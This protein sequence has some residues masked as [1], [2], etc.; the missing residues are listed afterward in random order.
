M[1]SVETLITTMNLEDA[2]ALLKEMNVKSNFLIGNQ[3]SENSVK[4]IEGGLVISTDMRGVGQNRNSILERASADICVL[5][6]DDMKFCD[7]YE[8]IVSRVFESDPNIDVA[9]FNFIE[10]SQGRRVSTKRKKVR[11]HNY[12]NYGAAR[13]AFR[14]DSIKYKGITFNTKFGGGTPHQCGEDSLFLNS[15]MRAGLKI[16]VVPEALAL[17]TENRESTWFK[18]YDDKYLYDKGVFLGIAHPKLAKLMAFY[19]LFRHKEYVG[20]RKFNECYRKVTE[21]I[22]FAKKLNNK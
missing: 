8:D 13:F 21:G 10:E 2:S 12:M 14:T 19:L 6:D 20:S 22:R 4:A 15:C 3:C 17:L 1:A 11:I 9:I 16:V 5:A 7:G 18:G